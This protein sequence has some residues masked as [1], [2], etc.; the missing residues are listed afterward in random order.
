VAVWLGEMAGGVRALASVGEKGPE[1]SG[2]STLRQE[3]DPRSTAS[4][5]PLRT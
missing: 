4:P 5:A 1:R 2:A 3:F